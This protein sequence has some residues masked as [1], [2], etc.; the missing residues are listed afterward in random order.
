MLCCAP[1]VNLNLPWMFF[2]SGGMCILNKREVLGANSK[3]CC[4]SFVWN[5]QGQSGCSCYSFCWIRVT[6]IELALH[7]LCL[8]RRRSTPAICERLKLGDTSATLRACLHISPVPVLLRCRKSD[9]VCIIYDRYL[10]AESLS[11]WGGVTGKTNG[12]SPS[13]TP[14]D[15][16]FLFRHISLM[17]ANL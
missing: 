3:G 14:A 2:F 8:G 11:F 1:Y 17:C 7:L 13:L 15:R 10:A 5:I 9:N 12:A 16:P 6:A 4:G